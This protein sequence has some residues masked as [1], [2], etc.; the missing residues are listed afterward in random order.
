MNFIN[1]MALDLKLIECV[2]WIIYN[3][4]I[5]Y[6]G[7]STFLQFYVD[8]IICMLKTSLISMLLQ[9]NISLSKKKSEANT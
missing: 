6:E 3:H 8:I 5:Y 2:T 7:G 1:S 4:P 9:S